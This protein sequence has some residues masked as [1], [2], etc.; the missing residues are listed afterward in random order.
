ME[1][2]FVKGEV[3]LPEEYI[4]KLRNKLN[5]IGILTVGDYDNV[6]SYSVV[7]GYWRPFGE[8][9][10]FKGT[11]GEI[12]YGTECK[13]EFRCLMKRIEEVKRLIKNVHPYEE[14]IINVIPIL[15]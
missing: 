4:E 13:M 10:P 9:N 2:V 6:V 15:S 5:D 3:L 11:K 12:S 14:P 7:K 8:A 1:F